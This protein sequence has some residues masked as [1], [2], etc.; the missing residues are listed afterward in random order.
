[1]I[2]WRNISTIEYGHFGEALQAC[3]EIDD[4]CRTRGWQQARYFVPSAG[5]SNELVIEV[6]YPDFATYQRETDQ[7]SQDA[8]FM[9][10]VRSLAQITYPQS[11]RS[12]LLEEAPSVLA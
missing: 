5:N 3:H 9:K 4:V 2:R 10:L 8:E 7:A 12:E 6:E 1:M 11:S